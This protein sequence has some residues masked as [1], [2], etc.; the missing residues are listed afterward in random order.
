M[1][2]T[3]FAVY[4]QMVT[5][6]QTMHLYNSLPDSIDTSYV[7]GLRDRALL[8]LIVFSF[9]RVSIVVNMKVSDCYRNGN[10]FWLRLHEKG[11][12]FHEAPAHHI[13]ENYLDKYVPSAGIAAHEST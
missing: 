13:A 5:S 1:L 7:I 11:G 10:R 9:A 6:E 2:K 3:S 12:K 8:G 4:I